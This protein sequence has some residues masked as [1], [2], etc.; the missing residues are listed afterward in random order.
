M[1]KYK[2]IKLLLQDDESK[3][4]EESDTF[5]EIGKNYLIRT[6]T[7]I[8]TGKVKK[9]RGNEVQLEKAAWIADTGRFADSLKS[10]DFD[11]VEP[12]Y[13]DVVLCRS[14]FLDYTEIDKLPAEQK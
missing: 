3:S 9:I 6:V 12:Y 8:Y 7:M 4:K 5:L 10:C 1:D 13:R 2:L 11:E 14:C